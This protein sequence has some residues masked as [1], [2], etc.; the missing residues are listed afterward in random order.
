METPRSLTVWE[1]PDLTSQI[2]QEQTAAAGLALKSVAAYSNGADF[3]IVIPYRRERDRETVR[4]TQRDG[5]RQRERQR[6]RE[7]ERERKKERD[8]KRKREGERESEIETETDR[9]RVAQRDGEK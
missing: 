1:I 4:G 7:R 9:Q 3:K 8:R 2:H 6:K 5:E